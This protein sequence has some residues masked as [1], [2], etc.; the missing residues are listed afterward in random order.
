MSVVKIEK[1]DYVDALRGLAILMVVI[2]HVSQ[3][4]LPV[5]GST[6]ARIVENGNKGVQL[7]FIV[8]ALTLCFSLDSRLRKE[9]KPILYFFI[10]RYLRIAPLFYLA[11]ICYQFP[12]NLHANYYAPNGIKEWYII[13][14]ATFTHGWHPETYSSVVPGGWSIAVEFTFYLCLPFLFRIIN[15]KEKAILFFIFSCFLNY[16]IS[17]KIRQYWAAIYPEQQ[18][19][20]VHGTWFNG[21]FNQLPVFAIGIF[22]YTFLKDHKFSGSKLTTATYIILAFFIML[23][24][25]DYASWHNYLSQ[26]TAYGLAFGLIIYALAN[27]PIKLFV[28]PLSKFAGK[29]SY[30]MYIIHFAVIEFFTI[31]NFLGLSSLGNIGTVIAIMLVMAITMIAATITYHLIEKP[32]IALGSKI[33][34]AIEKS[35]VLKDNKKVLV[36]ET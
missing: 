17:E 7:F 27:K 4:V 11:I 33:I 20:L 36:S 21:F 24:F 35:I 15:S 13:A 32:G 8:S 28:N 9:T 10:R 2:V 34:A 25:T 19:Y 30:S 22:L 23:A 6:F 14:T 1:Y 26:L 16:E 3:R 5:T 18:Y 31:R 29:I 12:Y